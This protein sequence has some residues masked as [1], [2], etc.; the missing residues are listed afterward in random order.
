MGDLRRM[1]A[2]KSEELTGGWR[3]FN[4]EELHRI[5]YCDQMKDVEMG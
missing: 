2:P 3:K 1:F 5:L 4:N